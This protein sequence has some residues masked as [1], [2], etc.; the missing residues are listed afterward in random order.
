MQKNII[1]VALVTV[2]LLLI[3]FILRWPWDSTDFIVIG[4]IIFIAGMAIEFIRTRAGKYKVVGI[5]GV[6]LAFMWLWAELAVGVFTNW[7]S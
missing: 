5:I 4:V 1:R 3:P 2:G 7:G 6:L